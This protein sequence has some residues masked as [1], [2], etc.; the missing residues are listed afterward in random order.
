MG[1]GLGGSAAL[2]AAVLG[3]FNQLRQDKWNVHELV[4]L[5]YQAERIDLEI[6]GGWQ[7]QYATVFG[8]FNFLEFQMNQNLVH[9]L[10]IHPDILLELEESL[11]L[12]DTGSTHHSGEIHSHQR[13]QM[14]Q[15]HVKEMVKANV[16]LTYRI[17]DHLLRGRLNEFGATL[18]QAWQLKKLFSEKIS[19]PRLDN[20]YEKALAHGA[21]GGKLLGAGGGGFFL[22]HAGPFNRHKLVDYLRAQGLSVQPFRFDDEGLKALTAREHFQQQS[23]FVK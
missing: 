8:G 6:E 10:R 21:L 18:N 4:E 16:A 23:E 19:N 12:C 17:R 13:Q 3:C 7:D 2:A 9:P 11:I 20:L 14:Q 15:A 22:F 5:A 1:S